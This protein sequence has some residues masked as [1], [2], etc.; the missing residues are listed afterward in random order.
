[1]AMNH[2]ILG[3][4]HCKAMTGYD[5]KK[6]VQESSF[7]PW[8]GNSNQI[9]KGLLELDALGFVSSETV[10]PSSGPSKKVYSL[11]KA[12]EAQLRQ[13]FEAFPEIFALKKPILLQLLWGDLLKNDTLRELLGQYQRAL[14][15]QLYEEDRKAEGG[16]FARGRTAREKVLWSAIHDNVRLSYQMELSWAEGLSERLAQFEK[17]CLHEHVQPVE[18]EE[19][20][21]MTY[22]IAEKDGKRFVFF[23]CRGR[24]CGDPGGCPLVGRNLCGKCSGFIAD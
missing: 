5:L 3:L 9:Y 4:L 24:A 23:G 17:A 6:I 15:G 14:R 21:E 11:T 19:T 20:A 8:S 16:F 10:H 1:M 7:L 22:E 2:T 13:R 12:G 18:G